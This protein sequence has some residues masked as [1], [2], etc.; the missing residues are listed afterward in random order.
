MAEP[1]ISFIPQN[2]KAFRRGLERL[3]RTTS[4]FRTPFNLIGNHWYRGNRKLF[5]LQGK[6]LYQKLAPAK[7]DPKA[8]GITTTSN[9]EDRKKAKL[10]F[11]Y[12][13]LVGRTR[14]LSNSILGRNNE[15]SVFFVGKQELEMGTSISYAKFHQSDKDRKKIPQRKMIFIDGGPAERARDAVVSGRREAWL[16]IIN[17]HVTQLVTGRIF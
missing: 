9:Y 2:D 16:N 12:P 5:T 6:G 15:G 7:G 4:D 1:I 14:K 17:E 8:G 11:A 3:A 10:G 13:A